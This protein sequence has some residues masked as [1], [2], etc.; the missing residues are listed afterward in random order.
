MYVHRTIATTMQLT[1]SQQEFIVETAHLP[2]SLPASVFARGAGG[3]G[4]TPYMGNYGIK[5]F[6]NKFVS[7]CLFQPAFLDLDL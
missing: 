2:L 7:Y 5:Q 3:G 4:V 1:T 6:L